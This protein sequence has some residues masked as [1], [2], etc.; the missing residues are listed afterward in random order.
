MDMLCFCRNLDTQM[1]LD[2]YTTLMFSDEEKLM[3]LAK[4]IEAIKSPDERLQKIEITKTI[5]KQRDF[6]DSDWLEDREV[7]DNVLNTWE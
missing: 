4:K 7:F 2:M 5:R 6:K 3:R 1:N